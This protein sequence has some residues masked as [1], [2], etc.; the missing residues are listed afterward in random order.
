MRGISQQSQLLF[1][2]F[3]EKLGFLPGFSAC[4]SVEND[5]TL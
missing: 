2:F 5:S 1:R 3:S 4:R